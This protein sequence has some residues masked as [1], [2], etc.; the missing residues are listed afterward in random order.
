ML[1]LKGREEEELPMA[2]FK[3]LPIFDDAAFAEQ[4]DLTA[5]AER[6]H[7][8]GPLFKGDIHVGPV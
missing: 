8:A 5:G 1:M 2:N 6:G 3:A 4:A 7:D